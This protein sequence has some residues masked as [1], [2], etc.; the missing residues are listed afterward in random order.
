M[1]VAFETSDGWHAHEKPKGKDKETKPERLKKRGYTGT[2][3][4]ITT[5]LP[6]E[7]ELM[8]VISSPR[9]LPFCFYRSSGG[10]L[11]S[12]GLIKPNYLK[13]AFIPL[14]HVLWQ[15]LR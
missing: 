9:L 12:E 7:R 14:L 3:L 11:I 10:I 2:R 4:V 1:E 6:A 15:F 8:E 5:T 13:F